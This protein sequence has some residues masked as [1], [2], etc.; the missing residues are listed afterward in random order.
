MI[1]WLNLNKENVV[2]ADRWTESN[3]AYQKAVG[4]DHK[5]ILE[6]EKKIIKP[7]NIIILNMPIEMLNKRSENMKDKND[8]YEENSFLKNVQKIYLKLNK[9]YP[10]GTLNIVNSNDN[11]KTVNKNL[12]KIIK[13]I[14]F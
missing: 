2:L 12:I 14:D 6:F 13:N 1:N 7:T 11:I 4:I 9:Y 5:R 8:L 10:Y 3:I